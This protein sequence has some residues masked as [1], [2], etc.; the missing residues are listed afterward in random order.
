MIR[1]LLGCGALAV[2]LALASAAASA[3]PTLAVSGAWSRPAT[4]TG[5]VYFTV[6]NHGPAADRLIGATSPAAA[7]VELHET[8]HGASGMAQSMSGM[9]GMSGSNT[10]AGTMTMK[11]VSAVEIPAGGEVTFKPG[12]YHVMLIGLKKPLKSGDAVE[13]QLQFAKAG[14]IGIS[15]PVSA[16]PPEP[17]KPAAPLH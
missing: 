4:Q 16:T 1:T 12:S 6:A 8:V 11:R 14:T 17:A 9:S 2:S 13:L 15:A 5:A 3:D 7:H 10:M